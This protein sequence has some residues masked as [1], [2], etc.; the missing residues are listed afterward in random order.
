MA[1]ASPLSRFE[2]SAGW[3]LLAGAL[4]L[5]VVYALH[6]KMDTDEPQHLH[7][8]W[9]WVQG[10]LPYRDLFD[11]HMP[12]FHILSAPLVWLL[13]ERPD[14]LILMRLAMLPL[15]V[16]SLA[17]VYWI[18]RTLWGPRVGL[19]AA[20]WAAFLRPLFV[21]SVE[22]R[23]DDLWMALWLLA[24][25][26]LVRGGLTARRVLVAGLVLGAAGATSIKT[27]PLLASLA[28]AGLGTILLTGDASSWRRQVGRIAR[29]VP[30]GLAGL[31]V[32]PLLIV[33]YFAARGGLGAFWDANVRH[34][35]ASGEHDGLAHWYLLVLPLVLGTVG[36]WAMRRFESPDRLPRRIVFVLLTCFSLGSMPFWPAISRQSYLV[37]YPSVAILAA[38]AVCQILVGWE[39]R[40][41][42]AAMDPVLGMTLAGLLVAGLEGGILLVR[43]PWHS[44][45]AGPLRMWRDVLALSEPGE[46]VMDLKGELI[47]RPRA[48]Y[49]VFETM[50]DRRIAQGLLR[51]EVPE[52][53]VQTRTCVASLGLLRLPPRAREFLAA[54]YIPVG[55]LRVVG[56]RLSPSRGVV[57]VRFD[58][59]IATDYVILAAGQPG[60]G[61]LDGQPY[62]G[63][64]HLDPGPHEYQPAA[65][66]KNLVL[67]WARAWQRGFRPQMRVVDAQQ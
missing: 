30:A 58:V 65:G 52:R 31:F 6:F 22:Y 35:V 29:L 36:I 46:T 23:A 4:L 5:R 61:V 27:A 66:E 40:G 7:V 56:K 41:R 43:A 47:F 45:M 57:P 62:T 60:S 21:D 42:R 59:Q 3:T 15:Y 44:E 67:L 25:A 28:L 26:L 34:N 38:A 16:A 53:L 49:Y 50:T 14:L 63:P 9:C 37:M 39:S 18:G 20:V 13:G 12:L 24:V 48:Y 54:N 33:L 51:D 11:N 17:C 19:W 32:V 8:A 10:L 55:G 64:R 2:R 1:A